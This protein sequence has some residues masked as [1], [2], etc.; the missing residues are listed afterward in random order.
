MLRPIKIRQYLAAMQARGF[1]PEQVLAG[2][3]VSAAELADPAC[4]IGLDQF[5]TIASNVLALSGD[6]GIGFEV[7]NSANITA[8][9]IVG[10]AMATSATFREAINLWLQYAN[11]TLGLPIRQTLIEEPDGSWGVSVTQVSA[12]L[13]LFQ[14]YFEDAMASAM[15]NPLALTGEAFRMKEVRLSYPAP[16][17]RARYEE[18]FNCPIHFN[19]SVTRI[20]AHTPVLDTPLRGND[21]QLNELCLMQCSQIMRQV[22]R[23]GALTSRVRSLLLK[24]R[25]AIPSLDKAALRLDMSPRTLRRHLSLEHTSY[26]KVL[27][28]LRCDLAKEYL[29]TGLKPKEIGYLLGYKHTNA[30]RLAFKAWTGQTLGRYVDNQ[31]LL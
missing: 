24:S 15:G 1:T 17:H 22:G 4:L 27:D 7:G 29:A 2:A 10:Y 30:F 18:L 25:G 12:K 21:D 3:E 16:A 19:D 8:L 20:V 5:D 26:Q 13:S 23:R 9:G 6:P 11:A 28:E 14:F 31:D